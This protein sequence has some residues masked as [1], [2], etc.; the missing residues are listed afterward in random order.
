MATV[1]N[2]HDKLFRE[3]WSDLAVAQ[4]FLRHYLPQ[5]VLTVTDLGTL[6]ICKDSF[7]EK[8]LREYFSDMLYKVRLADAP[9][10]VYILFEHKSYEEKLIHLQLLEYML[11]IW[12]LALK[13]DKKTALPVVIPL[14]LYHGR[15]PWA[16]ETRLSSLLTGPSDVLADYIPDFRF[17]L[18]DLARFSDEEIKGAVLARV[19]ML[20]FKHIFDPDVAEKLPGIFSLMRELMEKETGLQYI[21]AV[22]RYLFH[23]IDDMSADQI[24]AIVEQSLTAK[25]GDFIMTL[26]EKLRQEGFEKGIRQGMEKGIRQGMEKGMREGL[27]EGIELAV[28]LKFPDD[29]VK[30]MPLIN[31]I[32][33]PHR[34]KA[35]KEAVRSARDAQELIDFLL[36]QS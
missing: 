26:A 14:V 17:V 29:S 31:Q 22:M 25:E 5:E 10:Y 24:K 28:S 19:V 3:T 2:P 6:E 4:S 11:K 36:V 33:D 15:F 18:Y 1:T 23:T 27:M 34:L 32:N 12:Q 7:V 8:E 13:Q 35:V 16:G 21:E 20:I 30:I 9:G